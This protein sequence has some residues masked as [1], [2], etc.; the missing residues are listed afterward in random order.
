MTW[1]EKLAWF[2]FGA[3]TM[4]SLRLLLRALRSSPRG[5]EDAW[6]FR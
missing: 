3:L 6:P 1:R 5:C 2:V 4:L